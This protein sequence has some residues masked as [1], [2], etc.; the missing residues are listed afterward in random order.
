[1][2]AM[3]GPRVADLRG[4]EAVLEPTQHL[5]RSVLAKRRKPKAYRHAALDAVLR[6]ARTRDEANLLVAARAAGVPVPL[7]YDAD[8]AG[9]TLLLEPVV[10]PTLRE[11]LPRDAPE[12]AAGRLH[13]LGV[14][15][16]RLHGAGLVHGDPTAS[17]VLVRDP[18]DARSLV[19]IDFGLGAFSEDAEER[20]VDL[21]LVEEA[22]AATDE[23]AAAL[24]QA[25]LDG[26]GEAG[27]AQA[28]RRRLEALRERGRYR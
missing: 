2:T 12:V 14:L 22:L 16:R 18:R 1:M 6:D 13:Q 26:Y 19:L 7:L 15:L 23:R 17:N 3:T 10:G 9:A 8:R 5:G 21:H 20:A 25:F 28:A 11:Q 4:A 24:T 27:I